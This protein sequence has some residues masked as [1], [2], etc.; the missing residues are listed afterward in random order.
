MTRTIII[1]IMHT[2]II[3]IMHEYVLIMHGHASSTRR[4]VRERARRGSAGGLCAG[5]E[6]GVQEAHGPWGWVSAQ[7]VGRRPVCFTNGVM[8]HR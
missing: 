2:I 8:D 3:L 4:W 1:L 5:A 6:R 7:A